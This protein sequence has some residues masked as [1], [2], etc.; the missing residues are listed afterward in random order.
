MASDS[1]VDRKHPTDAERTATY[2]FDVTSGHDHE[3]LTLR[4]GGRELLRHE[5]PIE[6]PG[7]DYVLIKYCIWGEGVF[8]CENER[9]EIS[10]GMVFW[11]G[12]RHASTVT[13][14]AQKQM[15]NFAVVLGG[16]E[17]TRELERFLYVPFGAIRLSHPRQVET[18]FNAIMDEGRGT[19]EHREE[20]CALLARLL[21]RR[22][23]G[24]STAAQQSHTLA[25]RT[26]K[27]CREHIERNFSNLTSL[28]EVADA[29][30]IGVPYLCRLFDQFF[31]C[32]PYEYLTRLKMNRAE[33]LLLRPSPVREVASAVGY[34]DA[35]LFARNFKA[36]FG[37][38]PSQ[39][40]QQHAVAALE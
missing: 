21:F 29:C 11:T 6:T 3:K 5:I 10:P 40:R 7:V 13:A 4:W 30:G 31:K 24:Y 1:E 28:R 14:P 36:T 15:A 26:F 12:V 19:A 9:W 25:R 38:S 18:V 8:E 37:K 20:S 17:A 35:K 33:S 16:A 39:F 23:D 2:E 22:I 27:S 34:K 32:S